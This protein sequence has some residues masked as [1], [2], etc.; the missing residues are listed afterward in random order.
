MVRTQVQ[1]SDAQVQQLKTLAAQTGASLAELIRQSVDFYLRYSGSAISDDARQQA[2]EVIGAFEADV[3]DVSIEHD[4]YL[5]DAFD[6][7]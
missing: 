1:L 6:N 5:A 7:R 4:R 2:L 3:P